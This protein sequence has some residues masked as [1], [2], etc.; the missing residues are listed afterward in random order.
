MRAFIKAKP[1]FQRFFSSFSNLDLELL[2]FNRESE[3]DFQKFRG[4]II[5]NINYS[6]LQFLIPNI[7]KDLNLYDKKAVFKYFSCDTKNAY[8]L[9]AFKYVTQNHEKTDLGYYKVLKGGEFVGNA[10]WIVHNVSAQGKVDIIERGIHL[11]PSLCSDDSKDSRKPKPR[12]AARVMKEVCEN[13]YKHREQLDLDGELRSTIIKS[14]DRSYA[15]TQ[16]YKL[17]IGFPDSE[18]NGNYKW[19]QKIG[20]FLDRVPEITHLLDRSIAE[21]HDQHYMK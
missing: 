10:G 11:N 13:L 12:V 1:N 3:R 8:L 2:K 17:N 18:E 7:D 15:F 14:N 5:E 4:L 21:P 16:K 6:A 9:D 19:T 20:A